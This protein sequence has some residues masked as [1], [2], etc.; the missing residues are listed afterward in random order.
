MKRIL[1]LMLIAAGLAAEGVRFNLNN[2]SLFYNLEYKD[3]PYYD[4]RTFFGDNLEGYFTF[5]IN[6]KVSSDIGIILWRFYGGNRQILPY[7]SFSFTPEPWITFVFGNLKR[8]HG[9][10]RAIFFDTL[11]YE[12]PAER[13][14]QFL[15]NG[16]N[17]RA[18]IW[19]NWQREMRV[20]TQEKFD[21]GGIFNLQ[22]EPAFFKLQYHYIHYGG[23]YLEHHVGPRDET[24]IMGLAGISIPDTFAGS[25]DVTMAYFLS[26]Y[27]PDRWLN[28]MEKG[29]GIEGKILWKNPVLNIFASYWKGNDFFHEDGDPLYQAKKLVVFGLEKEFRLKSFILKFVITTGWVDGIWVPY[30]KIEALWSWEGLKF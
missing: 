28:T 2:Y 6:E 4:G 8:F 26:F 27:I 5:K 21:V 24:A 9:L 25:V 3:N 15:L 20:L 23:E 18:D 14:F 22:A 12:R 17:A 30:Q 7:I 11:Y 16:K 19:I 1:F 10:H 13:G 29:K